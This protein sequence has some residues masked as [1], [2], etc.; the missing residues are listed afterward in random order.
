MPHCTRCVYVE[1]MVSGDVMLLEMDD[2]NHSMYTWGYGLS[3]WL[4]GGDLFRAH[5]SSMLQLRDSIITSPL[6]LR[7]VLGY[8]TVHLGQIAN[9]LSRYSCIAMFLGPSFMCAPAAK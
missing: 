9:G 3:M 8:V 7:K 2:V 5:P 1:D 6:H 4:H